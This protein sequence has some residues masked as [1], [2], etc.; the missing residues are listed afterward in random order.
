MNDIYVVGVGMTPFG[1]FLDRTVKDLTR[2]AVNGA[3]TDAGNAQY[4]VKPSGKVGVGAKALG[5]ITYLG[6]PPCL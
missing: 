1:K 6:G 5:N 2:E 4:E 3:L